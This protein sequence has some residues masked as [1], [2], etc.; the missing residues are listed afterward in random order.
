[1]RTRLVGTATL[2]TLISGAMLALP[3][4]AAAASD[5]AIRVPRIGGPCLF[6]SAAADQTLTLKWKD[7]SGH[8][9]EVTSIPTTTAGDPLYCSAD[10]VV[11]VDD[12]L[13]VSNGTQS[14]KL[15]VPY[16]TASIGRA[17]DRMGGRGP[18]G[19]QLTVECGGSPF[20]QFEPCQFTKKVTVGDDQ[21]WSVQ[22]PF[23][24]TGGFTMDVKWKNAYGDVV[25][26]WAT[27]PY[28]QIF[29]N[30][31]RWS[32]FAIAESTPRIL[33]DDGFTGRN[34]ARAG[35]DGSF[36]GVIHHGSNQTVSVQPGEDVRADV[37]SD[38]EFT[39]PQITATVN[40]ATDRVK[41]TC[42]LN[43]TYAG[44]YV[45][46]YRGNDLLG[47]GVGGDSTGAFKVD[48]GHE[49]VQVAKVNIK[50]GDT[51]YAA[52]LQ[53]EGDRAIKVI[54]AR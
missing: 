36:A 9:K 27:T 5:L 51:I 42:E 25:Y 18:A 1:M 45:Q 12:T 11:E 20:G 7:A 21:T 39:V 10:N 16:V 23:D 38:A 8:V 32:G 41:G 28:F 2:I 31:S 30:D 47:A 15:K 22:I 48:F 46:V 50:P 40:S 54:T 4:G 34:T 33:V 52:C 35:A 37:A 14:H 13:K 24:I 19:K 49:Q 3:A 44:A 43:G 26:V 6:I 17:E 29:L 53:G